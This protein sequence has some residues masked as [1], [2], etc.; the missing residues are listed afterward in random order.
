MVLD[1]TQNED[2]LRLKVGDFNEP[3]L[4]PTSVYTHTLAENSNNVNKCVPIIAVYILAIFAQ[5]THERLNYIEVWSKERY[6]SY[7]DWLK[8]VV[9]N[10]MFNQSSPIP[11][12]GSSTEKNQLIQFTEDWNKSFEGYTESQEL[13]IIAQG[14]PL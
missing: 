6:D 14:D 8:N 10:P 2:K 3:L 5:Q 4:L 7:K 13:H 11:Y 1:L 12:T 9:M